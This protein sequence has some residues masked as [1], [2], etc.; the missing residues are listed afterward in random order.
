[1]TFSNLTAIPTTTTA[2]TSTTTTTAA[3]A[4]ATTGIC[5]YEI[6]STGHLLQRGFP[7]QSSKIPLTKCPLFLRGW[8]GKVMS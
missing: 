7:F 6:I 2:T 3:A 1:M 5:K 8:T 4:T